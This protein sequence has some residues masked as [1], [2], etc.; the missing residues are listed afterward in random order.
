MKRLSQ[1]P[2]SL[3]FLGAVVLVSAAA[4][5]PACA[6]PPAPATITIH[7]RRFAFV[8]DEIT[9]H[10][11]QPVRLVFISDDVP[12]AISVEGLSIDLPITRKPR[13]VVITPA[14]IAELTG[15]CSRYCGSGHDEMRLTIHIVE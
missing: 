7:A 13:A 11:G 15:M 1:R 9:V 12:H 4:C 2:G 5:R 8:P 10:V 6:A 14:K 3:S